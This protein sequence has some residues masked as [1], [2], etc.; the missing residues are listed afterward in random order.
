MFP[1]KEYEALLVMKD[2]QPRN[3]P[4]EQLRRKEQLI[5]RLKIGG[6]Q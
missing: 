5:K 3:D 6:N 2:G 4:A 1:N